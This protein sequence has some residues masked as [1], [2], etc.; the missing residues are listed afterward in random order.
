MIDEISVLTGETK[1]DAV[2][3]AL[4]RRLQELRAGTGAARTL[5]WLESSVWPFL[6]EKDRGKAPSK[7]EQEDLLGF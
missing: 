6:P 2:K 3:H 4:R 5:A 1:V 7:D